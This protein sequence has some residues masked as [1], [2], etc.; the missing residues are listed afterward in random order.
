VVSL[1]YIIKHKV[2]LNYTYKAVVFGSLFFVVVFF[3]NCYSKTK[4]EEAPKSNAPVIV[5]IM[6]AAKEPITDVI[7][8]NGTVNANE[9]LELRPEVSGRLTY[10]NFPEGKK[11]IKGTVVARVNDAELRAQISKSRAQLGLAQS[12][13]ERYKKLLDINGINQADYD[14]AVNQVSSLQADIQYSQALVDKTIVRAPFSGV[15]G[16]RQISPGAYV[17][18]STVI[19]TL[20]QTEQVKI[21]F[22]LP[23]IY[24]NVINNGDIIEVELDGDKKQKNKA[25]IIASEPGANTETRNLKVRALLQDAQAKPGAFVKVYLDAG[26]QRTSIKVPT[27][28]IIPGDRSNQLVLVKNGTARFVNVQ[29]GIREANTVEVTSGVE[30]GDSIVVTGVLFARPKS[31]L[32]VRAVKKIGDLV[33]SDED[34]Q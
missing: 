24:G 10:L 15:A 29:T 28:C 33:V 22:T 12:T 4:K 23:D 11:I 14:A 31:K 6:I 13:V 34:A 19:A 17:T 1:I 7:E 27:N 9:Y 3:E 18:P 5:D 32:Q 16:L 26:K 8:A 2:T 25:I 20:Q 21:D 30:E